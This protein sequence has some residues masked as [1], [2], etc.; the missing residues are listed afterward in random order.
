MN[1]ALSIHLSVLLFPRVFQILYIHG[2]PSSLTVWDDQ[3]AIR[4]ER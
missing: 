3:Q 1:S 2:R 4:G